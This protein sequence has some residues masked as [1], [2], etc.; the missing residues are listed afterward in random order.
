ML[1]VEGRLG[2]RLAVRLLILWVERGAVIGIEVHGSLQV[3]LTT[4]SCLTPD[5]VRLL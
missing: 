3:G 4:G 1:R 5:H 2:E